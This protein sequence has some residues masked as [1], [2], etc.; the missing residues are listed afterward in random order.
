MFDMPG[1]LMLFS[2]CTSGT[3]LDWLHPIVRKGDPLGH[4]IGQW[5]VFSS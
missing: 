4:S 1:N 2:I 5:Y 3:E